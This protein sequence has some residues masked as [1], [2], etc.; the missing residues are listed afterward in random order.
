MWFCVSRLIAAPALVVGIILAFDCSASSVL[1][2]VPNLAKLVII[3]NSALPGALIVVVLL[4]AKEECADTAAAVSKVYLPSYLLS[5]L[6]IAA[7]CS[8]GLWV[9]L[10]D[11]GGNT[12]C[13][14]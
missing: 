13:Q 14:R 1:D 9:T 5:I 11:E 4:K 6:T 2:S 12:F 10:P 3:V 7:W 8:V